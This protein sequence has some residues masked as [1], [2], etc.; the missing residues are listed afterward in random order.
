MRFAAFNHDGGYGFRVGVGRADPRDLTGRSDTASLDEAVA[1]GVLPS[2]AGDADAAPL[3][4]LDSV[5]LLA[6]VRGADLLHRSEL[7][8]RTATR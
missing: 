8:R 1:A 3:V 6:P 4:A 5:T 2:L 7:P